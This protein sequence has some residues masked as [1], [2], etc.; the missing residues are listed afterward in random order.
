MGTVKCADFKGYDMSKK[1][2]MSVAFVL[3]DGSDVF[4]IEKVALRDRFSHAYVNM[5]ANATLNGKLLGS[6]SLVVAGFPGAAIPLPSTTAYLI[7]KDITSQSVMWDAMQVM[8]QELKP[9]NTNPHDDAYRASVVNSLFYKLFLSLQTSLP[10]SLASAI[11]HFKRAVSTGHQ[12][13]QNPGDPSENPISYPIPKLMEKEQTCGK[14]VYSG[15]EPV[16]PGT[17]YAAPV[18]SQVAVGTITSIDPS[19]AL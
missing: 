15:D 6:L 4:F 2:L 5:G 7:G 13:Y 14:V 18:Y 12:T 11:S 9:L 1:V 17:L 10:P 3:D 8:Q 19:D 16:L